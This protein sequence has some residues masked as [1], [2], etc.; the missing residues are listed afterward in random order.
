MSL[1]ALLALAGCGGATGG[2]PQNLFSVKVA[3][4]ER[5]RDVTAPSSAL[6]VRFI[7]DPAEGSAA[8]VTFVGDRGA[9][10]AAHTATY[11]SST[12]A[13]AGTYNLQATFY[14]DTTATGAVVGTAGA[15]VRL[16]SNGELT[17]PDGTPLADIV[18]GST[19]KRVSI[20]PER[21][22]RVS[23]NKQLFAYAADEEGNPVVV[24]E[25]SFTFTVASGGQHLSVTPNGAASGLEL[26]TATVVATA[27]GI[28]SAPETV[29]VIAENPTLLILEQYADDLAFDATRN[30]LYMAQPTQVLSA[31]VLDGGLIA[32]IGFSNHP[33]SLAVSENGQYLF[34]GGRDGT[35]QRFVIATGEVDLTIPAQGESIPVE[36]IALPGHPASVIVTR[37]DDNADAG[38]TVYDGAVA[39]AKTAFLG[40]SVALRP[41]GT[42]IYGYERLVADG[43]NNYHIA[44][45]DANGIT[46]ETTKNDVLS[47][48]GNRIHWAGGSIVADSG[49]ILVPD[50]GVVIGQLQFNTIDH[51][52]APVPNASRVHF[53]A[54]DPKYLFQ[55]YDTATGQRTNEFDLQGLSGGIDQAIYGGPGCVVFRT[56]GEETPVV[57]IVRDVP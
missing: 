7:L 52:A 44:S 53:T 47:G 3:W 51:V 22:I 43:P 2:I 24:S 16:Q 37:A 27:D 38:T 11:T 31:N 30:I 46:I 19:I 6:S 9:N 48:F 32:P 8:N 1:C 17:K 35:V 10:M 36:L 12:K 29:T 34:V 13:S 5:T 4:P 25:G 26:G 50:F 23:E 28:V 14:A 55:T 42:R 20:S 21:T 54:W 45:L 18:F 57:G 15:T 40:L 56:F 33:F 41:D 49:T 39:R